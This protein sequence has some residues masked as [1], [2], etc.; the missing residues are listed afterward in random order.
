MQRL[1]KT[2]TRFNKNFKLPEHIQQIKHKR[3]NLKQQAKDDAATLF[4][5]ETSGFP[6]EFV[7]NK[8]FPAI[9]TQL[10][11]KLTS[12]LKIPVKSYVD[13]LNAEIF[14]L[15]QEYSSTKDAELLQL[16]T[17]AITKL[18]WAQ[19]ILKT[20]EDLL[21]SKTEIDYLSFFKLCALSPVKNA[22]ILITDAD[23]LEPLKSS[24]RSIKFCPPRSK[25]HIPVKKADPDI[26]KKFKFYNIS[27]HK[28]HINRVSNFENSFDKNQFDKL[29]ITPLHINTRTSLS[30]KDNQPMFNRIFHETEKSELVKFHKDIRKTLFNVCNYSVAE[31]IIYST[32]SLAESMNENIV[33]T[34]AKQLTLEDCDE[35][36]REL[37]IDLVF[38]EVLREVF[39]DHLNFKDTELGTS[40]YPTIEK[41]VGPF[42]LCKLSVQ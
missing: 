15:E 4:H 16:Y 33:N 41:N 25:Q 36:K 12:P 1:L 37:K 6:R 17:P 31:S 23:L 22:D 20:Q 13:Q 27:Q 2:S 21:N 7:T 30:D 38:H 8:I 42:Y 40:V 5:L 28:I 14:T 32:E 39:S 19:T 35:V 10:S 3:S 24:C 26:V 29:C 34:V 11:P 18:K 9:Q